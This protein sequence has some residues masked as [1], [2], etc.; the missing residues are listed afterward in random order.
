MD[1]RLRAERKC[2]HLLKEIANKGERKE[3]GIGGDPGCTEKPGLKDLG[4]TK[5]QSHCWQKLAE[6]G[7]TEFE[8][9]A[10]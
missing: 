6:L 3:P 8:A 7:D 2:G 9:K 4:V 1:I 5:T 10:E